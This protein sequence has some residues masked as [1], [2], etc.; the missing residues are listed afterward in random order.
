MVIMQ[1]SER[2]HHAMWTNHF[3]TLNPP[4][5]KPYWNKNSRTHIFPF[6]VQAREKTL[7][8]LLLTIHIVVA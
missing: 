3:R 5:L 8:L 7:L 1:I 6:L 4:V 2:G